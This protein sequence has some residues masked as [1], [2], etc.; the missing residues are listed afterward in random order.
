MNKIAGI[1]FAEGFEEI[2]AITIVDVLRRAELKVVTIGVKEKTPVG[3]HGIPIV[4]DELLTDIDETVLDC[5]VLPGGMPGAENLA[6]DENVVE[7]L[8]NLGRQHKLLGAICAAPIALEA[9]RLINRKS[10]TCYPSFKDH[11]V[12]SIYCDAKTCVDGNIVTGNGPGAALE[13]ALRLVEKLKSTE[14]AADLRR[15][16]LVD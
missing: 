7:L 4:V 13:F 1:L 2:E 3:S 11:L 9:A 16:M 14:A 10:V 8:M 12:N 6:N 5:V 15:K